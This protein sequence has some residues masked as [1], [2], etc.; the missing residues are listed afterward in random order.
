MKAEYFVTKVKG[1][2]VED[3]TEEYR[4]LLT[5]TDIASTKDEYW[6]QVLTL[7]NGLNKEQQLVLLRMVREVSLDALSQVFGILD[8]SSYFDGSGVGF[9]LTNTDGEIL[10][11][12]LQSTLLED[13]PE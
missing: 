2:V 7:Y 4:S 3:A 8:G 5:N 9:N 1:L 12:D 10:N 6:R 13:E 11:G